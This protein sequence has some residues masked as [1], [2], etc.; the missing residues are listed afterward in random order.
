MEHAVLITV[1]DQP[2]TLFQ[3]TRVLA[4]HNANI[5]YV[6][7]MHPPTQDAQ[8]YFE[9]RIEGSAENVLADLGK[10]SNVRQ[11]ESTPPFSHIYG[12]RIVIMGGGAQ[13]GQV[14][15]GAISEADRHNIRGERI[16]VD[17]IPLVGEEALASAVRAVV[18][19][20]RVRLLVLAGSI[21]GGEISRAVDE[22]RQKGLYVISLNMAGSVPDVADLVVSDPV[23]AGVMAVMAV[24]DTA[25]F[26]IVRQQKRRY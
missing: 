12:K 19:L 3:L 1:S 9:F 15:L 11:V 2:G 17:T 23:Q 5:S 20:P 22:V 24:A 13:V 26:D 18:R 14:A 16:S 4:E 7:I 6:D 8:V 21:M 25:K 10:I